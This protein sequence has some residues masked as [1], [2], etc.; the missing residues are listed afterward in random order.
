MINSISTF[1]NCI[2]R[3]GV[4]C[5]GNSWLIEVLLLLLFDSLFIFWCV[6]FLERGRDKEEGR[7]AMQLGGKGGEEV[8]G[9]VEKEK[10]KWKV[11]CMGKFNQDWL[12]SE[13][14][15]NT[16]CSSFFCRLLASMCNFS[17]CRLI[18]NLQAAGRSYC[19]S[20]M[21]M[22]AS[23]PLDL[24]LLLPFFLRPHLVS[25]LH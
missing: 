14:N 6:F 2:F 18:D 11:Y 23:C 8:L 1:H 12:N 19:V 5:L 24:T 9:G 4:F 21:A 7:E 16:M 17:S 15:R 10:R 22:D 13:R 25:L 20:C 3:V